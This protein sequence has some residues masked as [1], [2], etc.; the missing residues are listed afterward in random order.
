MGEVSTRGEL[1]YSSKSA[2]LSVKGVDAL[3][4][5]DITNEKISQGR[6]LSGGDSFSV[7]LGGNIATS[8][9]EKHSRDKDSG[10]R[11]EEASGVVS[12][13]NN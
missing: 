9:F 2:S 3:V 7:V 6:F 1:K 13:G 12:P 5:K 8:T 4:W 11:P 10:N